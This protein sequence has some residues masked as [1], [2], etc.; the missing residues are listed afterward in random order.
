MNELM[1]PLDFTREPLA[2]PPQ[3]EPTIAE[4]IDRTLA[5]GEQQR[6]RLMKLRGIME[7]M[8]MLDK[9]VHELHNLFVF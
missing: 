8:A 4:A 7:Q 5:N 6:V 2:M 1:Q 3:R 9:P